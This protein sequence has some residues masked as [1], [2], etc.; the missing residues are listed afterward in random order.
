[1][2]LSRAGRAKD[3][4]QAAARARTLGKAP[5]QRLSNVRAM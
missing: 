2:L 3:A 4:E 1:M 5:G